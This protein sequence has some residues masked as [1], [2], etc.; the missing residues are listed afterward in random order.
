MGNLSH[1][2]TQSYYHYARGGD[3]FGAQAIVT[4]PVIYSTAAGTGGPFL[5]NNTV[6]KEA[7]IIGLTC[8][9]TV[10]TT[11]AAALGITGGVQAA[12]VTPAATTAIDSIG[13]LRINGV[14]VNVSSMTVY[15]TATPSSPGTF[16]LPLLGLSTGALTA[17]NELLGFIDLGGLVV[18]PPGSWVSVA[19][20]ATASTTVAQIG[21]I[22][23]ETKL[24]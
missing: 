12:N 23:A 2:L 18:V 13:N 11:V 20:S 6:D 22:W 17:D 10:V 8:A 15:R 9:V 16:F 19:A 1:G 24:R 7:I 5:W 14:T 21:M 4:A 3:V